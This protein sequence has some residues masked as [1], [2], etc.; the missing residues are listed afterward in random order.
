MTEPRSSLD[1]T[2]VHPPAFTTPEPPPTEPVTGATVKTRSSRS[3][4]R[5]VNGLLGLALVLAIGG[6]AFAAGRM[7]APATAAAGAGGGGGGFGRFGNGE[8]PGGNFPGN[9]QGGQRGQGG[10]GGLGANGG[11]TVQGTVESISGNT[12]TLKTAS[13]QTVQ[14]GLSGTTTYH[15]QASA[16]ATD[17][18]AGGTVVVRLGLRDGQGAE[19]G[20]TGPSASDV[21]VVP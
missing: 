15:A 8:F 6:V 11:I 3:S 12:L 16:S 20:Q 14:I 7:T 5:W 2:T 19:G 9:G 13:G 18:K 21:T 17:V 10:F 1:D 4:A